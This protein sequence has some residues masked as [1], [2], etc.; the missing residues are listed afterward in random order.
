MATAVVVATATTG[1]AAVMGAIATGILIFALIAKEL[2]TSYEDED[3]K[4]AVKERLKSLISSLNI[5]ITPMLMVFALIVIVEV[6]EVI[7]T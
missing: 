4:P 6:M 2:S 3:H 1:S 5:A 7:A